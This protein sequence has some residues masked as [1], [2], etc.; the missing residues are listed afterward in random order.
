MSKKNPTLM[1]VEDESMLLRAI[2]KKLK[3]N[4]IST[5]SATKGSQALDYL[6]SLQDLPDAIWLD[7]YLNEMNGLVFMGKLKKD[8]KLANIP[9][10]VISNSA[11]PEKVHQMLALGVKKYIL[12]ADHRLDELISIIKGFI[13]KKEK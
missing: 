1:V 2:C 10:F 8:P 5:I 9:V 13:L 11:S 12:K 7:Y 4:G 3:M 6:K